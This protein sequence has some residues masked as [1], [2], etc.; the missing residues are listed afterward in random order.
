MGFFEFCRMPFGLSGAPS[1]FQRFMDK[2]LRGLSYVTIYLDD[3]LVHSSDE[4]AHKAHLLEVFNRLSAAG[5]TL[6]GRKCRIGMKTIAYLGHVFSAQGMA[7][8]PSKIQAVQEWPVPSNIT[9]V[10]Q[11]LGLAS[12]YR[13]YIQHFSHI[14]APLHALTQKNAIFSWTEACQQAFTL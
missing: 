5:V 12:Y 3:I 11:F 2:I 7:P 8:D 4:E 6:R 9:D 10:R 14:A 1:S 13:R